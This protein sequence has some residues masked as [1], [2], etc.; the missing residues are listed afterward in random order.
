MATSMFGDMPPQPS[1]F[2]YPPQPQP[3]S[4]MFGGVGNALSN[5]ANTLFM[6]GM[7]ML[8]GQN[9]QQGFGNAMQGFATGRQLDMTTADRKKAQEDEDRR[10]AALQA[11]LKSGDLGTLSPEQQQLLMSDPSLSSAVT[12]NSF[13][14]KNKE[15]QRLSDNALFNP[16]TGETRNASGAGANYFGGNSVEG[17]ALNH[18]LQQGYSKEQVDQ[19]A[20]GKTVTDPSTGALIFMTPQGIFQKPPQGGPPQP[21]QGAGPGA[22]APAAR[23]QGALGPGMIPLT[24]GKPTQAK[25]QGQVKG[26]VLIANA[27]GDYQTAAKLFDALGNRAD[28]AKSYGGSLGQYFQS[29]DYQVAADSVKN[30]VQSYIYA[31]SGAQA[32]ETEVARMMSLVQPSIVDSPERIAAKKK[33][34]AGMMEAIRT[35]AR[36]SSAPETS[37]PGNLTPAGDGSFNWTP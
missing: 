10:R 34:L 2:G 15:W 27:E 22:G 35:A 29:P 7:G 1:M 5:N 17:Q 16:Q 8:S 3:P 21:V 18:L 4:P 37:G 25:S 33:R 6:A 28:L 20:A 31:V 24:P 36:E 19:L 11:V 12:A 9:P 26:E 23:P 13:I 14:T 30:V 32:P